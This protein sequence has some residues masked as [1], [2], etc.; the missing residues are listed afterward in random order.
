MVWISSEES[1]KNK[2]V[3]FLA[4]I[5]I[6]LAIGI[7][8]GVAV[9]FD[10]YWHIISSILI[11][12]LLLL[13]SKE[14]NKMALQKFSNIIN[15]RDRTIY[16]KKTFKNGL[17]VR[18]KV[19]AILLLFMFLLFFS[20]F[21]NTLSF[22]HI[23]LLTMISGF[24]EIYFPIFY[25]VNCKIFAILSNFKDG[26]NNFSNNWFI[27]NFVI[28]NKQVPEL[29][30]GIEKEP[31]LKNYQIS[32]IFK[33]L[34][35]ATFF[36]KFFIV[37]IFLVMYSSTFFYRLSIKS[38][39]WFYIPLLF[40]IKKPNLNTS[41]NI[42]KFLSELYQTT[43]V[44]VRVFLSLITLVAFAIT[45]FNFYSFES[46]ESPFASLLTLLY[47]DFSSLEIWKIFQLF[48]ALLTI[49]LFFYANAIRVPN[50]ENSIPLKKDIHI[51]MIFIL[52]SVRNWISLFYLL[53]AFIFLATH[54]KV[55]E[56]TYIPNSFN[57]FFL[58]LLKWI[59]Y[60]PFS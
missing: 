17:Q 6:I 57:D 46:I 60:V 39:F 18:G 25:A 23:L 9:Y 38:T 14:S 41:K 20:I 11:T 4:I 59:K 1:L 50:I 40:I 32:S 22:L 58:T 52:N 8:W 30:L 5:E 47:F 45:H 16:D 26:Y 44:K 2:E 53:S 37:P 31:L 54:F 48:V 28:D 27:N 56:Y 7:Y 3:S 29:I 21:N 33:Q 35:I 42:G 19:V 15:R 10:I 49:G 12:P 43:W 55:W 13:R 24:G 34:K 51:K 36:D